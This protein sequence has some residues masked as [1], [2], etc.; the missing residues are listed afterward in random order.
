LVTSLGGHRAAD[1][2]LRAGDLPLG[3]HPQRQHQLLITLGGE[4]DP[5]AG[6]G[7]PQL[8]A[9]M[10][11]QRGHEGVLAAVES[12]LVLADHDRVERTIRVGQRRQQ[13]RR[14]RAPR[15]RQHPA[16][17]HI[18]E[19]RH[20][21]PKTRHQRLGLTPLPRPRGDRIL[22]IFGRHPPIEREPQPAPAWLR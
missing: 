10:L 9:V 5:P 16:P 15:P 7:H 11:E 3:L 2:D 13:R 22:M 8:H 6:L 20:D 4:I 12:P 18:E 14:L 21:P 1:P 19:L 17:A